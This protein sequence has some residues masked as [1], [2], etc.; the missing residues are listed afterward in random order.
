MVFP[1]IL[2]KLFKRKFIILEVK[3]WKNLIYLF[4]QLLHYDREKQWN[5]GSRKMEFIVHAFIHIYTKNTN[6]QLSLSFIKNREQYV[7]NNYK[8]SG[9]RS[10][11]LVCKFLSNERLDEFLTSLSNYVS[12][13]WSIV[14]LLSSCIKV[15]S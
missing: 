8:I 3:L 15:K 6:H 1:L 14:I 10:Y 13:K 4:Y 9:E 2:Y 11:I 7:I 12:Y 5:R